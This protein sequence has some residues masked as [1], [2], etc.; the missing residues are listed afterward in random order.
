MLP[1][2]SSAAID[3]FRYRRRWTRD[4]VGDSIGVAVELLVDTITNRVARGRVPVPNAS[5]PRTDCMISRRAPWRCSRRSPCRPGR[6]SSVAFRGHTV[7][8][9]R[10][11]GVGHRIQRRDDH[12]DVVLVVSQLLAIGER[13]RR[14]GDSAFAMARRKFGRVTLDE[15]AFVWKRTCCGV[16]PIGRLDSGLV[17]DLRRDEV[18]LL[19]G[20]SGDRSRDE[21]HHQRFEPAHRHLSRQ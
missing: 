12:R 5:A 7:I 10:R 9:K 3:S 18:R 14:I 13:Q 16:R 4:G 21:Q 1:R 6:W 2:R 17:G 11:A 15:A 19:R 20:A 8:A